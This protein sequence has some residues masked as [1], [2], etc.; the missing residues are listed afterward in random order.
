MV[1]LAPPGVTPACRARSHPPPPHF[2]HNS[3]PSQKWFFRFCVVGGGGGCGHTCTK[4]RQTFTTEQP[5]VRPLRQRLRKKFLESISK[6]A[7]FINLSQ[8]VLKVV[9]HQRKDEN[10]KDKGQRSRKQE[11]QTCW[12]DA[13]GILSNPELEPHSGQWRVPRRLGAGLGAGQLNVCA[14]QGLSREAGWREA[15]ETSLT[16]PRKQSKG[17]YQILVNSRKNKATYRG[18]CNHSIQFGSVAN[19]IYSQN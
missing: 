10:R 8:E 15:W 9:F 12:R 18:K 1:P 2:N 17:K 16:V 11:A 7:P 5:R 19:K 14:V 6:H 4:Y 3:T 13:N